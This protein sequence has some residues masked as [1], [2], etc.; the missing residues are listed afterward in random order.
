[1][2]VAYLIRCCGH[3]KHAGLPQNNASYFFSRKAKKYFTEIKQV[4]YFKFILWFS[5]LLL[6]ITSSAF[7]RAQFH[8]ILHQINVGLFR[9]T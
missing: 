6:N 1:M 5:Q 7:Y 2:Y 9:R 3:Q 8:I 4:F